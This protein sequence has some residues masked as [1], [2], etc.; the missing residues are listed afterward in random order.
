[1]AEKFALLGKE[2]LCD[3]KHKLNV[4]IHL[5]FIDKFKRFFKILNELS[6]VN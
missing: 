2:Q 5:F 3:N 1:M 4:V 6:C